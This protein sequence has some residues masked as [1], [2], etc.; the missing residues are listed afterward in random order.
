MYLQFGILAI[1]VL[2][3]VLGCVFSLVCF[4]GNRKNGRLIEVLIDHIEE[5]EAELAENK[6]LLEDGKIRAKDQS[7]RIAW[8]ESRIRKPEKVKN[9]ILSQEVLTTNNSA[10][11]PNMTERRHRVLTLASRGQ[12]ADMISTN[13]G[14]LKGEVELIISLGRGSANYA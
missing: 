7:R 11:Q 14:M 5:I 9:D 12:D 4:L 3:G 10:K 6:D 8:L 13:L 1:A 2:F